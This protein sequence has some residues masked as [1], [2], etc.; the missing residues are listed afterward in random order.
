MKIFSKIFQKKN[1]SFCSYH[2]KCGSSQRLMIIMGPKIE[3]RRKGNYGS[4]SH[5]SPNLLSLTKVK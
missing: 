5:K 3:G 4:P 1:I 2:G